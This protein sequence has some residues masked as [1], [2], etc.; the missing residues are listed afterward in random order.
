MLDTPAAREPGH[1][2]RL[3]I[4]AGCIGGAVLLAAVLGILTRPLDLL[5][6]VWPANALLLGLLLRYPERATI[7][8]WL[9]GAAGLMAAD[10]AMGSSIPHTLGLA[11]ANLSGVICAYCLI[12]RAPPQD[13]R[14][15]GPES[16]L[17]LFAICAV[18]ACVS[19]LV[20]AFL[21]PTLPGQ[22]VGIR[23][24]L[25]FTN[26][27]VST[28]VLLP[29]LLTAPLAL[30]AWADLR[31]ALGP[32]RQALERS[33]PLAA[34]VASMGAGLLLDGP[35]AVLMPLPALLW[36]AL[37]YSLLT[38]SVLALMLCVWKLAAISVGLIGMSVSPELVR[39]VISLRLSVALL[40]LGPMTVAGLRTAR[41]ALPTHGAGRQQPSSTPLSH[42]AFTTQGEI[43]LSRL[44]RH[45]EPVAVLMLGMDPP[46][47]AL[48]LPAPDHDHDHDGAPANAAEDRIL[49]AFASATASTLRMEDLLGKL[50]HGRFVVLIPHI[51]Q[52]G[53]LAVADR[54]RISLEAAHDTAA[55]SPVP[56]SASIGLAYLPQVTEEPLEHLMQAA[57]G[58]LLLARS[59]GNSRIVI[60]AL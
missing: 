53:A 14:L 24:A 35:A 51:T 54:L 43:R 18:A 58:A 60:A 31:R 38:T 47:D 15:A 50:D 46:T 25:W 45:R 36:C 13:R 1:I 10:L 52:A 41:N 29:I 32:G 19:G 16:V 59:R 39:D 21:S 34:L 9:G 6:M 12:Q 20:G 4:D 49:E 22:G 56:L 17:R 57:D 7:G 37:S 55:G 48:P 26:D 23:F 33:A 2:A 3:S 42:L 28:F 40:A 30:P 11:A 27:L 5:A 8:G 44:A